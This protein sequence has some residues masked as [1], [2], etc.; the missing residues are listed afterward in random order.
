MGSHEH[1][2]VPSFKILLIR[3]I[4]LVDHRSAKTSCVWSRRKASHKEGINFAME[5]DTSEG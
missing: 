3:S 5:F 4:W 1:S 2:S